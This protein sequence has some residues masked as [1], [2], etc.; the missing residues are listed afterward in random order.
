[1]RRV[2]GIINSMTRQERTRPELLKASRKRRIAAGAG[3]EVAEVNRILKMH[4]GMAD[5]MK[6]VGKGGPKGMAAALGGMMGGGGPAG[7]GPQ[8][9]Q[10]K[11]NALKNLGGGPGAGQKPPGLG[12]GGLPGLGGG[13][14]GLG[15][16]SGGD[17]KK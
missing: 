8:V 11:L 14:P 6:K 9:D 16:S 7:P 13:L 5:M 2:E 15:G 4:R 12:G 3:V 17:K 10:A 1:M